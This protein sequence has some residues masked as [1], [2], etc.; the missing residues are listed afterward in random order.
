MLA[1][2]H[3]TGGT[4]MPASLLTALALSVP[5]VVPTLPSAAPAHLAESRLMRPG[6]AAASPQLAFGRALMPA[7]HV[8][9]MRAAEARQQTAPQPSKRNRIIKG[10]LIG[11]TISAAL[12][13]TVGQEACLGRSRW[14]CG[15]KGGGLGA[16]MGALIAWWK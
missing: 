10:A 7:D 3:L 15:V 13:M 6:D 4:I 12:M 14:V 2:R 1:A 8:E 9:P 16:V 5:I 11:G